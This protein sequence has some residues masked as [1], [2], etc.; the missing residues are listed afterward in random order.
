[1]TATDADVIYA[2]FADGAGIAEIAFAAHTVTANATV[3]TQL[4]HRTV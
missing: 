3:G 4:I 1:M 2:V